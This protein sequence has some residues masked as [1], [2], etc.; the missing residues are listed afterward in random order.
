VAFIL[1]STALF[2]FYPQLAG[3]VFIGLWCTT[4]LILWFIGRESIHVVAS[5]LIYALAFF[6]FFSGLFRKYQPLVAISLIV[7]FLYGSMV[8][9][10]FPWKATEA[11]SWEGHLSGAIA[12]LGF[13]IFLRKQGPQKPLPPED[14]DED[15]E[16]ENE[17]ENE[18]DPY[19]LVDHKESLNR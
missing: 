18:E 3:K 2:Y 16:N 17:N 15:D 4:G 9:Q 1:L 14:E 8:W 12:G 11:L 13:A 10:M 7:V 19:W 5:G 6:L